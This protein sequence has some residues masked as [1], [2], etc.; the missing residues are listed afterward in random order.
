MINGT[1][2]S[3]IPYPLNLYDDKDKTQFLI[4]FPIEFTRIFPRSYSPSKCAAHT[5]NAVNF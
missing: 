1:R 5:P 4:V 3:E 2:H